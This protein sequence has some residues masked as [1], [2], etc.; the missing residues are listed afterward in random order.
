MR[1]QR[2]RRGCQDPHSTLRSTR[3]RQTLMR[4]VLGLTVLGAHAT[5]PLPSLLDACLRAAHGVASQGPPLRLGFEGGG[6]WVGA[7]A[8]AAARIGRWGPAVA[9]EGARS[10]AT[11]RRDWDEDVAEGRRGGERK[12]RDLRALKLRQTREHRPEHAR[13]RT[14]DSKT[15]PRVS[16]PP[17]WLCD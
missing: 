5:P 12:E 15:A 8:A 7:P 4:R 10:M 1:Q 14:D 9:P 17:P 2:P 11:G 3:P 16:A 13:P 6:R